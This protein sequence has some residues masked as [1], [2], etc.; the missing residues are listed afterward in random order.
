M[1]KAILASAAVLI[2]AGSTAAFAQ[3]PDYRHEDFGRGPRTAEE[4]QASAEA[5]LAAL[6]SDLSLTEAQ[7]VNWPAFEQAAREWQKLRSDRMR[8]QAERRNNPAAETADP[9]E[10]LRRRGTALADSGAALK[11]LADATDALYKSLDDS[12]KRRFGALSRIAGLR[13]YVRGGRDDDRRDFRDRDGRDS[14]SRDE[15]DFRDRDRRDFRRRDERNFRD[16]DGR[17]FRRD[18]RNFRDLDGRDSRRDER[19]FRDLDG[20]DSRRDERDFRDRDERDFRDRDGR[21]F[22]RRDERDFRDRDERD[23]RG[24]RY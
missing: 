22:R 1:W 6:K 23:F 13:D 11:K 24:R 19:D 15:R 16:R 17:D 20:R 9:A 18:E 4:V 12:Q 21:D 5:R 8:A 2:I 10:R 7:A 14:R 3:R